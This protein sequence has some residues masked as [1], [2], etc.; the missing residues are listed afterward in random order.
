M[1]IF[2]EVRFKNFLSS[3][4]ATTTIRLDS[5]GTTLVRGKNGSGKSSMIDAIHFA[6]FGTTYRKITKGQIINSINRKDC[7]VELDFTIG[8]TTYTVRRGIKPDVFDI[9]R[10]GTEMNK[11]D[12][13]TAMQTS[14]EQD[15]LGFDTTTFRQIFVIGTAAFVPFMSLTAPKRREIIEELLDLRVIGDMAAE[16][17]KTVTAVKK[18]IAAAESSIREIDSKIKDANDYNARMR[19]SESQSKAVFEKTIADATVD[20]TKAKQAIEKYNG[21][22]ERV[23]IALEKRLEAARKREDILNSVRP[24][25]QEIATIQRMANFLLHSDSCP[26]CRQKIFDEA[27]SIGEEQQALADSKKKTVAE[28]EE[29]AAAI[30]REI[31]E[32]PDAKSA[33]RELETRIRKEETNIHT[34]ESAI[35]TAQKN[36]EET[37]KTYSYVSADEIAQMNRDKI[38]AEERYRRLCVERDVYALTSAAFKDDGAKALIIKKYIPIIN[39]L[40]NRYLEIL[41][42]F[43]EFELDET[44][45]ETIRSRHRDAFSYESFSEGEKARIS[46]AILLTWRRLSKMRNTV[47]SNLLIMD[48]VFDGAM[49]QAGSSGLLKII[50]EESAD[51]NVIVISHKADDD[52]GDFDRVLRFEKVRNFSVLDEGE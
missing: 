30:A 47:S 2:N 25:N 29:Q 37:E 24:I 39:S 20:I 27:K 48:E 28:L 9:I 13:K 40:I 17:A 22:M 33:K 21:T 34:L 26:T 19:K 18:D 38:A 36:I 31:S 43:V 8:K 42:F 52:L 1:I 44:F 14:L 6:L 50:Q 23:L 12:K 16:H 5:H 32:M 49:D 15:I 46:T 35:R 45:N 7:L 41:D 11:A 3:G 10:D 51:T 4:N